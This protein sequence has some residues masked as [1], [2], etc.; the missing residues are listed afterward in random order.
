M[1]PCL[2]CFVRKAYT[3]QMHIP[4][5]N[6]LCWVGDGIKSQAM[7]SCKRQVIGSLDLLSLHRTSW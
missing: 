7:K 5:I 2:L 1:G 6:I 3:V 4:S